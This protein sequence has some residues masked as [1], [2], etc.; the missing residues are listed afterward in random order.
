M[1]V[2]KTKSVTKKAEI[3]WTL[4]NFALEWSMESKGKSLQSPLFHADGDEEVQWRLLVF[5]YGE[6]GDDDDVENC[7]TVRLKLVSL[8]GSRPA[9]ITTQLSITLHDEL[10][11]K[12][13]DGK[14]C[15]VK[16]VF[17]K[18]TT[19]G[20]WKMGVQS[21]ILAC[22][23]LSITCK[24]EYGVADTT[25]TSFVN[26]SVLPIGA[27]HQN[28][29]LIGDLSHLFPNHATSDICFVIGG[30]EIRAHKFILSARS[31]VFA[32][33]FNTEMKESTENRAEIRDISSDVFEALVRFIYTDQV[34]FQ[35]IDTKDLLVAANRYMI[36]LLKARCE[37]QL[38][39]SLSI[40]NCAEMWML[41]DIHDAPFL[42]K[43]T[44]IFFRSRFTEVLKT[45]GWKNLAQSRADVAIG[46]FASFQQ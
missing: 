16:E 26:N 43:A 29:N 44:E 13:L 11:K 1:F 8:P 40:E 3:K 12:Q 36:P 18:L 33:M 17:A 27:A 9:S 7:F 35:E 5:P 4:E 22:E 24:L 39:G 31:P 21:E 2:V 20:F 41:A 14:N 37:E 30:Q 32:A 34:E 38:S 42:K 19:Y 6:E 10:N 46:I 28:S 23:S 25:E 15:Q 45:E